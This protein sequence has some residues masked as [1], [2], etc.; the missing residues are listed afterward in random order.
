MGT[1][2]RNSQMMSAS[3]MSS[4]SPCARWRRG[5]RGHG[6]RLRDMAALLGTPRAAGSGARRGRCRPCLQSTGRI[7]I[8]RRRSRAGSSRTWSGRDAGVAS[9]RAV[10]Y[11]P[12]RC[13]SPRAVGRAS[14]GGECERGEA[15]DSSVGADSLTRAGRRG[16]RTL[17]VLMGLRGCSLAASSVSR[18][19]QNAAMQTATFSL[20]RDSANG[21]GSR[22]DGVPSVAHVGAPG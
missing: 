5:Q 6:L 18:V 7:A 2:T 20:R 21:G 14:E 22:S 15:D 1:R 11:G 9:V 10:F 12:G 16:T 4:T 19:E 17:G 3:V 13:E 8:L